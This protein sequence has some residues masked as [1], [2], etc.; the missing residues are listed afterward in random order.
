MGGMNYLLKQQA[1]YIDLLIN[2]RN[3]NLSNYN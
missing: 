3:Y 2:F 1:L